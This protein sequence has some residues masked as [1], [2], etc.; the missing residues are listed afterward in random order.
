MEKVF[1]FFL[2]AT[3]IDGKSEKIKTST[4]WMCIGP[5]GREIYDT[6]TFT[7]KIN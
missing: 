6:F 5:K 4:L 3:E 1:T 7:M 2:A